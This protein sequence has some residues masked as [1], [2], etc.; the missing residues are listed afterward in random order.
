MLLRRIT[1][2]VKEQNWFAVAVDF[3][4]VVA[5][6]LIA[7]QI[8]N[9]N[10][11]R[12][13]KATEQE[14][15]IRLEDEFSEIAASFE[16]T[17][18]R[19]PIYVTATQDLIDL[20]RGGDL[21]SD[22]DLKYAIYMYANLGRPPL[23][24]ATYQQLVASG[25]LKLVTDSN[26]RNALVRYHQSVDQQAFLYPQTIDQLMQIPDFR[27]LPRRS[28]DQNLVFPPSQ[29]Y[30][31]DITYDLEALTQAEQRLEALFILQINLYR[32]AMLQNDLVDDVV[33]LLD[34]APK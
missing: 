24:S 2:H 15:I 5:G 8:T 22:Q 6:I 7:F 11:A 18:E 9:W 25:D 3:F 4:I 19:L 34:A 12:E 17:L 16:I 26:L 1:Q 21:P 14:L 23:R 30:L 28:L 27:N 20:A 31:E 29:S 32:A 13:A 10:A 33:T